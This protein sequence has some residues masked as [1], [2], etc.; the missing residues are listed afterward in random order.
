MILTD[1]L[2]LGIKEKVL[3]KGK[4][5]WNMKALSLTIQKLWPMSK[6]FADKQSNRAKTIFPHSIE[7]GA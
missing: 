2:D 3:P 6:F 4:H 1:D 5:T 7:K